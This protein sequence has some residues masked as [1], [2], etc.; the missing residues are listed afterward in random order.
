MA[1]PKRGLSSVVLKNESDRTSALFLPVLLDIQHPEI[2]WGEQGDSQFIQ[3][4]G[5]LRLVNDIRGV[6]YKGD[7][8]EPHYYAPCS[9]SA[10]MSKEDGKS[11]GTATLSVS[12]VDGRIIEVIR[13]VTEGVTCRITAFYS[14]IENENNQVKYVFSK[15][16]GKEFEM[17]SVTWTGTSAQWELNADGIMDL[18]APRD[19]GSLFRFPAIM[20]D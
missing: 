2:A 18:N 9:F 7:D 1:D 4:D 3:Q 5:H 20:K 15:L 14:K 6:M 13:S 8:T 19:K 12:A 10:K 16:Y 11:K 17:G